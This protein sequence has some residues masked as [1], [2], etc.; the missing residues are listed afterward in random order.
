MK[1]FVKGRSNSYHQLYDGNEFLKEKQNTE[2]VNME[3]IIKINS[4]KIPY[5]KA[6]HS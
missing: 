5:K 3:E 1:I 6:I 4:P 2:K